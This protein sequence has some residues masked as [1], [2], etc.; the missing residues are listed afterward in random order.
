MATPHLGIQPPSLKSFFHSRYPFFL[1][2]A[3]GIAMPTA[4]QSDRAL[5]SASSRTQR[6]TYDLLTAK[7]RLGK[8]VPTDRPQHTL[9]SLKLQPLKQNQRRINYSSKTEPG[10]HIMRAKGR[11]PLTKLFLRYL[12]IEKGLSDKTLANYGTDL[13][14][15]TNYAYHAEQPVQDLSAHDLHN[16]IAQLSRE[17]LAP[18]TVRRIASAVRGFYSFLALD[19]HIDSDPPTDDLVTP[20]PVT[21]LPRVLTIAEMQ[22]LLNAPDLS[23]TSGVRDHALLLLMYSAGLRASEVITLQ[24][25][26]V[27]LRHGLVTCFGKGRKERTIPIGKTAITALKTYITTKRL[28]RAQRLHLFLNQEQPLTRQFLWS[29]VSQYAAIAGLADVS[30]HTLRHTFATHMLEHGAETK[31]VQALLGHENVATTALYLH[32]SKTRIRETYNH[33]HPRATAAT[34]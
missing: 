26:N 1:V 31:H 17:G 12:K 8:R 5:L 16:F 34:I 24:Q 14:R 6:H 25:R 21:Y 15:L 23:T 3:S 9:P 7:V 4:P 2:S 33:H 22:Q 28:P 18:A 10:K 11:P 13:A 29:I 27:D 30:P 32:L 19:G 20:P